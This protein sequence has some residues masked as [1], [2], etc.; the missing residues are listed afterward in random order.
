MKKDK[1]LALKAALSDESEKDKNMTYLAQKFKM[2][3]RKHKNF[4]KKETQADQQI[5][6]IYVTKVENYGT[7]LKIILCTN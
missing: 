3:V 5:Q 2:I 4:M 6:L 7:L 1:S